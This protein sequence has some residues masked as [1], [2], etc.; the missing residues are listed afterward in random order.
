[1]TL[2]VNF[3]RYFIVLYKK[4]LK[5]VYDVKISHAPQYADIYYIPARNINST[6]PTRDSCTLN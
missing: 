2:S 3:T 5:R 4:K 6:K 1:M